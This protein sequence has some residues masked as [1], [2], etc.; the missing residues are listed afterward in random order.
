ML[1]V[2][3]L[4]IKVGCTLTTAASANR[5][6]PCCSVTVK[7]RFWLYDKRCNHVPSGSLCFVFQYY[8]QLSFFSFSR[9]QVAFHKYVTNLVNKISQNRRYFHENKFAL[10]AFLNVPE[11]V[12]HKIV[13]TFDIKKVDCFQ[14][15]D[16]STASGHTN[17][18]HIVRES[19][20]KSLQEDS[21]CS[22]NRG[23]SVLHRS[24]MQT[25]PRAAD[26]DIAAAGAHQDLICTQQTQL[27]LS[28]DD[29]PAKHRT[30]FIKKYTGDLAII[31]KQQQV[32]VDVKNRNHHVMYDV[33]C[34][35]SDTS[36]QCAGE[37]HKVTCGYELG[38]DK[39]AGTPVHQLDMGFAE[40]HDD[41]QA[42][43]SHP[44]NCDHL[45]ART[46]YIDNE[47]DL[48]TGCLQDQIA[49][50][51]ENETLSSDNSHIAH[52]PPI[53]DDNSSEKSE[54]DLFVPTQGNARIIAQME[55][56]TVPNKEISAQ[57]MHTLGQEGQE[58]AWEVDGA[59]SARPE[60]LLSRELNTW[61]PIEG[62]NLSSA[63]ICNLIDKQPVP[64]SYVP[65]TTLV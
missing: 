3:K 58:Q 2:V 8:K 61:S 44:P 46:E 22:S 45:S 64:D 62:H 63:G 60:I 38:N 41:L 48:S 11:H 19:L 53:D 26:R 52:T 21:V 54:F 28:V 5:P 15:A 34:A 40:M 50:A 4:S 31:P 57:L 1:L 33:E 16:S 29:A 9:F 20:I 42:V 27:K 59:Q 51:D 65:S 18:S 37:Q 25:E 35:G 17:P 6:I 23:Q 12:R 13:T 49:G 36:Q 14:I 30:L 55:P 47:K 32:V 7:A 43:A 39:A 24:Q 10:F 56:V